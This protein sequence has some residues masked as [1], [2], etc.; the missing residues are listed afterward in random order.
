MRNKPGI[1]KLLPFLKKNCPE[2]R[3]TQGTIYYR[4]EA[5]FSCPTKVFDLELRRNDDSQ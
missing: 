5:I 3:P 2:R 4:K 1:D